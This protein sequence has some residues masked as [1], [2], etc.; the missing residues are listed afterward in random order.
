MFISMVF[1]L[2]YRK[3]HKGSSHVIMGLTKSDIIQGVQLRKTAS[4]SH[5]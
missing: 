2:N 3:C 1:G 4:M 5:V